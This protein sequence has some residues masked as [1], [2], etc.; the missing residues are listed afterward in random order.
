MND[1]TAISLVRDRRTAAGL[2]QAELA[3]RIGVSR[4]TLNAI[5]T[6]R[7]V[8][9]TTLALLLARA[10]RCSV[11]ELFRL[12]GGPV[13]QVR[14]ADA[15]P[16]ATRVVV[17]RVD[18][19]LVAHPL[20][21]E[22][23]AA[24]G[25]VLEREEARAS[26]LVELLSDSA[27][28]D[29]NLLI[30][31]C[32]PLLGAL[33]GRLGRRYRDARSTWIHADSSRALQLVTQG[34]VHIAGMHLASEV[35]AE[36]HAR[37]ARRAFPGQ[38]TAIIHLA[39]WRQGLVV[40]PGNP[41]SLQAGADLGRDDVRRALRSPGSG[42]RQVFERAVGD[43]GGLD[44]TRADLLA[45]DHAEVARL[46]RMGIADVGV[47][48]ESAAI[49]EGLTF[50][51]LSEERFELLVPESRLESPAVARFVDLIDQPTF[52]A[53]ASLMP[54]YDLAAAGH[55]ATVCASQE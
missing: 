11:D 47:A 23:S 13:V 19:A 49:A 4:Q 53:E 22:R 26:A 3:A 38:N 6:G 50:I 9:S 54:G 14:L 27:D 33:A 48:I 46:V 52:R 43:P 39:R 35:D 29:C 32:A 16:C 17:G 41:L 21:D 2:S 51:P 44:M 45:A 30:A 37:A 40:A 18:G 7:Q 25:V 5:E 24:D 12:S 55:A 1:T 31:G 15:S 36:A 10:L 42:A 34:L 20:Q 28:V 8:P